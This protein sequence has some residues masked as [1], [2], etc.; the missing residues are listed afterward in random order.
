MMKTVERYHE[1]MVTAAD[2]ERAR[3]QAEFMAKFFKIPDTGSV[4]RRA[5]LGLDRKRKAQKSAPLFEERGL[6]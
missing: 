6:F 3:V 4:S 1:E 5:Q 2:E